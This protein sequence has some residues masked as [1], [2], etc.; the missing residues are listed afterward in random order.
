MKIKKYMSVLLV[1]GIILHSL[2]VQAAESVVECTVQN[3]YHILVN[4]KQGVT[5]DYKPDDLV[6]PNIK[7]LESGV[8]EKKH[9]SY[10]PA[11]YIKLLFRAALDEGIEFAGISGYRSYERQ[12]TIYNSYIRKYGK[13][14]T[15]TVSAKAGQSEHQTGLAMDVSAPS[16]NYQL[17]QRLGETKEGKWLATHAHQYGFIIRYPKDK[18]EITGYSYEPWHIRYVGIELATYLYENN[19]V[20]EEVGDCT[21]ILAESNNND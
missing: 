10:T 21:T 2:S 19:L 5:N 3:P 4:K 16:V 6:I 17:T 8:L 15:D 12:N 18:E 9:M 1:S 7:F 20:L 14:Y 11:Y 13:Q